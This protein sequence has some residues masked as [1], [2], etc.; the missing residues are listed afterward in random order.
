MSQI[1]E[2]DLA[3]YWLG[4]DG[5]VWQLITYCEYP[6]VRWERVDDRSIRRGGAVGSPLAN[7][8]RRLV[9][10]GEEGAVEA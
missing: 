8:F 7:E 2:R 4:P 1:T 3:T 9:V 6:T 5:H 10:A